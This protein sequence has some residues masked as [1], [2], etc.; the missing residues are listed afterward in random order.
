[1]IIDDLVEH[2]KSHRCSSHPVFQHWARNDPE[3]KVVGALFHQIRSFCD[4]TRPGH[5]FP[6]ALKQ[7]G[8][9]N[10]S[11]LL[12][13]IVASEEDHGPHLATMAGHIMNR[14]AGQVICQDLYDQ[15]AVERTLKE[16]SDEILGALPG[17][18]QQ[19]GLMPQTRSARAVFDRRKQMDELSVYRSLGTTLA[20]E[21]VSN[22]HLIPGE[23]YCL[24]DCGLYDASMEEPE[25]YYLLEHFGETGAEAMHEQHAIDAV[26]SV[27]TGDNA[28]SVREG[29]DDFLNSLTALW[30]LLDAALL[31]SGKE[32]GEPSERVAAAA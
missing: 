7:L 29:V 12:Q 25:M 32:R 6:D 11:D 23:K 22:R 27:V 31:E 30:D 3:P 19:T 26:G 21:M 28:A 18:D 1:M 17:Y 13:Q 16:C 15:A 9:S 5:S 8:L 14:A 4:A 10:G 24:V 2:I 20:L